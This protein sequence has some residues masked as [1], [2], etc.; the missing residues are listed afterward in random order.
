VNPCDL[1][2]RHSCVCQPPKDLKH[3]SFVGLFLPEQKGKLV[4]A[5]GIAF[6]LDVSCKSPDMSLVITV[7]SKA[8]MN[9]LR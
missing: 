7:A 5:H 8:T 3:F 2:G 6:Y 9:N 1:F 4:S